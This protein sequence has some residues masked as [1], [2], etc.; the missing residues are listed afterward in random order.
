M[1]VFCTLLSLFFLVFCGYFE[2]KTKKTM[3]MKNYFFFVLFLLFSFN[4]CWADV[5]E[6][7]LYSFDDK[8]TDEEDNRLNLLLPT[9]SHDGTNVT[10]YSE[11]ELESVC[12]RVTN[13][14]GEILFES[15]ENSIV[16][17][18]SFDFS[19]SDDDLLLLSIITDAV[20][21]EG[22]FFLK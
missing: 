8:K 4:V 13:S 15:M 16:D 10:I 2:A 1:H 17:Y 22:S 19:Y 11:K 3:L 7:P 6:I 14:R 12:V 21:Y 9:A 20:S 18:Y 5:V